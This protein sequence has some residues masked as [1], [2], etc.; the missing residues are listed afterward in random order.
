MLTLKQRMY[1]VIIIIITII[2]IIIRIGIIMISSILSRF[3]IISY[4]IGVARLTMSTITVI[5]FYLFIYFID[6]ML[7]TSDTSELYLPLLRELSCHTIEL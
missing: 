1:C 3:M 5:I 6:M 2:I 7:R 4:L